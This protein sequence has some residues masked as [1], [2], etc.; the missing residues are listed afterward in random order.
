MRFT[1]KPLIVRL[2]LNMGDWGYSERIPIW[3]NTWEFALPVARQLA[4]AQARIMCKGAVLEWATLAMAEYPWWEQAVLTNPLQALPQW[5]PVGHLTEG[6]WWDFSDELG[7]C[8]GR[9]FRAIEGTDIVNKEWLS[10]PMELPAGIPPLPADLTTATKRQLYENCFC[11]YRDLGALS[12]RVGKRVNGVQTYSLNR[13]EHAQYVRVSGRRIGSAYRRQSWEAFPFVDAP[14]FSPCGEVTG[15]GRRSFV[16]QC[17]FYPDGPVQWV[18]YYWAKPTATVFP[19]PHIFWGRFRDEDLYNTYGVGELTGNARRWWVPGNEYG[20][21]PGD[22]FSGPE[23]GFRG[24]YTP[25]WSPIFPTPPAL[26]PVCDV[27]I[28]QAGKVNYG[29]FCVGGVGISAT[30]IA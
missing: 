24:E 25:S 28:V 4:E 14:P 10:A 9:L 13:F 16:V 17:R 21:A 19:L 20:N 22:H 7:G 5:G 30:K 1:T 3:E 26:L 6:L 2:F 18:H 12:R 8:Q 11:T 27:P 15:V 29:C 23:L